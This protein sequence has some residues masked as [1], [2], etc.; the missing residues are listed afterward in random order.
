MF[1]LGPPTPSNAKQ[2]KLGP[3]WSEKR[4]SSST[5][6]GKK[7]HIFTNLKLA[8]NATTFL[9]KSVER[10]KERKNKKKNKNK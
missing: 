10:K 7:T 8:S 4:S 2:V 5:L 6:I 3:L 9:I 1:P